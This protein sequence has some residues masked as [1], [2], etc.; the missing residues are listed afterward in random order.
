MGAIELS[1]YVD[2]DL[3]HGASR[4]PANTQLVAER[5][6]RAISWNHRHCT[7]VRLRNVR[8]RSPCLALASDGAWVT[9]D[10]DGGPRLWAL[11]LDQTDAT[12]EFL[13]M[14]CSFA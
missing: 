11:L 8:T 3:T 9:R 6:H 12:T 5:R 13:I 7:W 4:N 2:V 10:R 1:F 14:L